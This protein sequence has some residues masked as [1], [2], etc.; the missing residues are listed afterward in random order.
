MNVSDFLFDR[1]AQGAGASVS[2][3]TLHPEIKGS[4]VVTNLVTTMVES[5]YLLPKEWSGN[6]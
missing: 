1:L 6:R 5:A 4:N 2:V 3:L